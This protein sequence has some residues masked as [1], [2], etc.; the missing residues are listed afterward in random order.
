AGSPLTQYLITVPKTLLVTVNLF[1]YVAF[2]VD[3]DKE[4][5][6][7]VDRNRNSLDGFEFFSDPF[8]AIIQSVDILAADGDD[9]GR[10][11]H[12]IDKNLDGR[13]DRYWD[14]DDTRLTTIFGGDRGNIPY[15]DVNNDGTLEFLY[16]AD[17]D[18]AV[19]H[20]IDPATRRAGVV[21]EKDFDDDGEPEFIIDT[22]GD[23]RPDRYFDPGR[24]PRGLVTTVQLAAGGSGQRYEIDTN[25]GGRPTKVYDRVTGEVSNAVVFGALEFV[26]TYW[27]LVLLFLAVAVLAGYLVVQRRK[28]RRGEGGA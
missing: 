2:D 7:A 5:E 26:G 20:W 8:T 9:D 21:I 27:Y 17:A 24:G 6:L 13:P 28:R 19:D 12:F 3:D 1:P 25:G 14:P 4:L 10:I 23:G 18:L 16:D 22:N 11:D 15:P